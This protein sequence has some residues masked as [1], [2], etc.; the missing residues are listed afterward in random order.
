MCCILGWPQSRRMLEEATKSDAPF[1]EILVW[2]VSRPRN[3]E[4]AVHVLPGD[5]VSVLSA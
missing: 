1:R 5:D 2:K 4:H 3:P